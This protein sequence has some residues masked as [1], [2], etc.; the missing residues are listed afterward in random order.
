MGVKQDDPR[1]IKNTQTNDI[2]SFEK[3]QVKGKRMYLCTKRRKYPMM[4]SNHE[5]FRI[6]SH[7]LDRNL[8]IIKASS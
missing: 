3:H 1:G 4:P 8:T 7:K 6:P 5:I 2:S